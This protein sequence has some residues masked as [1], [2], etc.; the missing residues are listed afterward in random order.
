MVGAGDMTPMQWTAESI[1]RGV[2]K[3]APE[4]R[5]APPRPDRERQVVRYLTGQNKWRGTPE[6]CS[7]LEI[8][9]AS[10]RKALQRLLARG[11]VERRWVERRNPGL[12]QEAQ[13]RVLP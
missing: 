1:V 11:V 4:P 5:T 7:A 8:H 13:W 12:Y 2:R 6:I 10:A 3:W 9:E